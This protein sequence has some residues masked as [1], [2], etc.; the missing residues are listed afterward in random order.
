MSPNMK[1]GKPKNVKSDKSWVVLEDKKLVEKILKSMGDEDK[2]S[3]F[4]SVIQEPR[5]IPDIIK[6]S[7]IPQTSGYRKIN[8]LIDDGLLI[9]QGY[10]T[11]SDGKK[12]MQYGAI[13]DD[14]KIM[15]D[16]NKVVVSVHM[17]QIKKQAIPKNI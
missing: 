8:A 5:T 9:P 3:I 16:K 17:Q 14:L 13:F 2:K 1:L 10:L 7:K 4:T 6:I 11:A 12:T 15:L